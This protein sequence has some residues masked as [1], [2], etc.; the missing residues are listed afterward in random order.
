ML[1][2][3]KVRCTFSVFFLL[4][5]IIINPGNYHVFVTTCEHHI[6]GV[7]QVVVEWMLRFWTVGWTFLQSRMHCTSSLSFSKGGKFAS[8]WFKIYFD[9]KGNFTVKLI[10]CTKCRLLFVF[11]GRGMSTPYTV[12]M[13]PH[14]TVHSWLTRLVHMYE[15]KE[16]VGSTYVGLHRQ[17]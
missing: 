14:W 3:L 9:L 1:A 5:Y 15:G 2:L 12:Q 7:F 8:V 17:R 11:P 13:A 10:W 16:M 4:T 6:S